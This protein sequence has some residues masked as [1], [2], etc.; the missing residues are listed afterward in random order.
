[1]AN[2]FDLPTKGQPINEFL[3][4]T[5]L[6]VTI[7]AALDRIK[8]LETKLKQIP[9]LRSKKDKVNPVFPMAINYTGG[10]LGDPFAIVSYDQPF[11]EEP[12]G[13]P[14]D[15]APKFCMDTTY[16]AT[17][18]DGTKRWGVFNIPV[19]ANGIAPIIIQGIA[20]V[21]IDV[22]D[23]DHIYA[24]EIVGDVTKLR[25]SMDGT[26]GAATILWKGVGTG[27]KWA[28]ILLGR[29]DG[30]YHY[31]FTLTEAMGAVVPNQGSA[32]IRGMDDLV[33]IT[34]DYVLDPLGIFSVLGIGDRGICVL[35]NEKF[36][37]VQAEC[38]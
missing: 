14:S 13:T 5:S 27:L 8:V 20:H 1:M 18:P 16:K 24:K 9:D 15:Y 26:T 28:S 11:V 34:T 7:H 6:W 17:I 32:S 23:E 4:D 19:I 33:A 10:D 2:N 3:S 29:A 25:S 35:Q 38:P 37:I 22:I 12:D 36:Y 31:L 21:Q 30:I